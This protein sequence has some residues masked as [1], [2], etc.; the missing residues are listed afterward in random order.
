MLA[1]QGHGTKSVCRLLR[2]APTGYFRWRSASPS[3][4]AIRRAWLADVIREIHERSR[5]TYGWQRVRAELDDAYGQRAN[6][7]LIQAIMRKLGI[8]GLP[9]RRKGKPNLINR[10]T[11]VDLVNREFHREGPNLLWMTD[12]T[13]H[14]TREEKLYCCAVL[15][16][17]SRK[18]VGRSIDRRPTAAMV[19]AA[20]GMAIEQR[21]PRKG[22]LVHSDH[23]SQYTWTFSQRVAAPVSPI[24]SAPSAMRTTTRWSN[25]FGVVCRPSCSTPKS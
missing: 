13:E 19:N 22:T 23:G 20:L 1:R 24:R 25:R 8:A 18:I 21:R 5:R 14:P 6:K 2:V 12:I 9:A 4:R 15:D 3:G 10:A 7:K 16:A 11:T 17:W